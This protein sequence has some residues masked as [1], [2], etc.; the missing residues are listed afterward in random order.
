MNVELQSIEVT[1]ASQNVQN[2]L[3][4]VRTALAEQSLGCNGAR[5]E[6]ADKAPVFEF[7]DKAPAFEF[8]DKAPLP[9]YE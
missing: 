4:R 2:R 9:R 5:C 3:E 8:A 7:A 6:F 1:A